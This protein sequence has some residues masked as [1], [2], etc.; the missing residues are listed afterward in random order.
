MPHPTT[1]V[2]D[3]PLVVYREPDDDEG[4]FSTEVK[5]MFYRTLA[6]REVPVKTITLENDV[7]PT[8]V[9]EVAN[10]IKFTGANV[11]RRGFIPNKVA[12]G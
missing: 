10:V 2:I 6:T 9:D 8:D 11:G 7:P 1:A 3:S 5:D 12:D 4:S